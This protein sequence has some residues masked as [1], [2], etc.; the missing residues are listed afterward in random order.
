MQQAY[1]SPRRYA[2]GGFGIDTSGFTNAQLRQKLVQSTGL[3]DIWTNR[4]LIPER[5][6]LR[7]GTITGE[8]HTWSPP[9][10]LSD[11]PGDRRVY[12]NAG[13]I[14]TV[15]GF[16]IQYTNTYRIT[17][18]ADNLYVNAGAGYIEVIASQPT[19]IGFPPLGYWFGLSEPVCVT[20]YTYGWQFAVTDDPCEADSPTLY[21]A[22]H[23]NW[24]A[25]GDV[26]VTVAGAEI[27]PT[28]YTVNLDDG[29]VTFASSVQ[30]GPNEE[31]LASYSYTLPDSIATATGIIATDLMGQSR[32]AAR[33]M[34]GL[35]SIRVAEVAITQ[36]SPTAMGIGQTRNGVTIPASA[37]ALLMPFALGTAA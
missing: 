7:G 15:T 1:I 12:L 26:T 31:V 21:F 20:D 23:G 35:Q 6:D 5:A 19:I 25:G 17:L 34:L 9:D 8:Q 18:P 16:S 2:L 29:S 3:V 36:M 10:A 22:S 33:G 4:T 37:A 30:P 11:R 24:L 28:D 32:V 27:D 14:R 13:P